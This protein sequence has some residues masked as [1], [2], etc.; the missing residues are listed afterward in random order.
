MLH[1]RFL[2]RWRFD[3]HD[4]KAPRCGMWNRA[5]DN[6]VDQAWS[7]SKDNLLLASIEAKDIQTKKIT[8][9]AECAGQDFCNFEWCA[10]SFAGAGFNKDVMKVFNNG[11]SLQSM[12][13]GLT[14]VSRNNRCTVYLD[15]STQVKE[16]D[17]KD[18]NF[19]SYGK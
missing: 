15:G 12:I 14:I 19:A 8:T 6:P 2:L 13:V 3:Y 9:I 1:N 10:V 7:Q 17:D 11:L 5:G 18:F 4:D 16:R